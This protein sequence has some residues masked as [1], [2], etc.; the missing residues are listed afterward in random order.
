[1]SHDGNLPSSHG[2]GGGGPPILEVPQSTASP[3]VL[4]LGVSLLCAGLSISPVLSL[5]GAALFL[6]GLCGWISQLLPGQ[7]EIEEPL[8][9]PARGRGIEARPGTV[10]RLGPGMPG[11]RFQLPE[12]VHP[13]SSGVKGGIVGGLVM[14]IAACGYGLFS[15]H[16][17]WFPINLLAGMV[18]P[19]VSGASVAELEQFHPGAFV[20]ALVIHAALSVTFGLLFGVV[21]PTLPSFA[22]GPIVAGGILMP[23]MWSGFCHGF[24]GIVNPVLETHVNWIWFVA[25]QIVYGLAMSIVVINSEKV[26]VPPVGRGSPGSQPTDLDAMRGSP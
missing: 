10:A 23:L 21:S 25:S 4:A 9:L 14:P 18:I 16:G 15:G 1:V 12:K 6:F 8:D 3:I 26:A 19:G 5:V 13:I 22:G 24:M 7:G 11:H 2:E 20:V 17:I